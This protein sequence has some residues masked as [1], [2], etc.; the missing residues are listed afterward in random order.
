MI[1][2]LDSAASPGGT[3]Q[4]AAVIWTD[5]T[6]QWRPVVRAMSGALPQLFT[7]GPY[8]PST[9]TGPVIWLRTVIERKLPEA[10][11]PEGK[12]PILY[13]PN[14]RRQDLRAAGECPQ[15]LR[16][17]VELQYRGTTW[18][19]QNGRDWT[20]DAFMT[21]D[22]GLQ[23]DI[24]SDTRTREAM[25]RALPV[26]ATTPVA[27][28]RG[29]RLTADDF[30]RLSVDD[31][32]RAVL[33][34]MNALDDFRRA[35]DDT[36]WESF[37]STC[38][39]RYKFDPAKVAPAHVATSIV[40]GEPVFDEIWNRFAEAPQLYPNLYAVLKQAQPKDLFARANE[41]SPGTNEIEEAQL[42]AKF[43]GLADKP[44]HEVRRVLQD[45][46]GRHAARRTWIWA[47][48][49]YA[50]LAE[51]LEPL[52]RLAKHTER[53][54]A[55]ATLKAAVAGYADGGWE[56]DNAAL[57]ALLRVPSGADGRLVERLVRAVYEPWLDESARAFQVL[58]QEDPNE[59]RQL[60]EPVAGDRGECV[61]F[62]DGLRFDVGGRLLVILEARGAKVRMGHRVTP[63]P[64]V[65][66]TG[67]PYA[68]QA[69]GAFEG[70]DMTEDFDPV[71]SASKRP[72]SRDLLR[73][74]LVSLGVDVLEDGHVRMASNATRGGWVEIGEIDDLGHR[75]N[76]RLIDQIGREIDT[77]ADRVMELL[78]AGW[79]RIRIVTDHGWLFL[80]G[81]LPKVDLPKSVAVR[82]GH[83]V[84]PLKGASQTELPTYAWHWNP[85][86]TMI[87]PPGIGVFYSEVGYAHGGV[88]LQE[89]V[90]PDMVVEGAKRTASARIASEGWS[91]LRC[92]VQVEVEGG[93][94]TLDIRPKGQ[95]RSIAAV[96]KQVAA[97]GEV[98][99]IVED[100]DFEGRAAEIVLL[101]DDN[102]VVDARETKVG[103]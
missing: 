28:L 81:S 79:S 60:A 3:V 54:F 5:P 34:W 43:T 42:R 8:D 30:D 93:P 76:D 84:A 67:K 41:R 57:E 35:A 83:R 7:L 32:V 63:L 46:D 89:C 51:V 103:G 2:S 77:I 88:T 59:M 102:R 22:K 39:S 61:V 18:H 56:A 11:P 44:A 71:I 31:P 58:V 12:V 73:K 20:V 53:P 91:G 29:R 75:L 69:H 80:P 96:S 4:P 49:G 92:R 40:N 72:Y 47:R 95:E 25:A 98:L 52:A 48:L 97:S 21:S 64:S 13:L 45:L 78:S 27:H 74:T 9:R 70:T 94:Y 14:V 86:V 99:L 10:M 90:I 26:L 62:V 38:Q 66:T 36:R 37:V 55:A 101:D 16:P 82:K 85:S 6:G 17:L 1:A 87:S 23:L 19:Q 15:D 68:S 33:V 100:D 24:A 50:S 65:T